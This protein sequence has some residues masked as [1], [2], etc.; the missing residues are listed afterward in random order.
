VV[1]ANAHLWLNKNKNPFRSH[2][3]KIKFLT[4][5]MSK[6]ILNID[7]DIIM[8][9]IWE[10]SYNEYKSLLNKKDQEIKK[11]SINK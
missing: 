4:P 9:R 2:T 5:V 11:I 10:L 3:I 1:I 6:D 7:K 8:N